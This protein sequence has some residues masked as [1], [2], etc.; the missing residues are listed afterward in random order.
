MKI[1][2]LNKKSSLEVEE[3][4][5][6][7][8]EDKEETKA[9]SVKD[10]QEYL[11]TKG[12][13]NEMK[14]LIN[15]TL[16]KIIESLKETKFPIKEER[17][18]IMAIW[19]GSISGNIQIALR[20]AKTGKWLTSQ[21]LYELLGLIKDEDDFVGV[22][23][24]YEIKVLIG[25]VYRPAAYYRI[26][27]FNEEHDEPETINPTLAVNNAG[28]IKATFSGLTQNEIA[29]ITYEDIKVTIPETLEYIYSFV[30]EEES[31]ANAVPYIDTV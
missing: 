16:D 29:G 10:F 28:F 31:F 27:D 17:N 21:D 25:D 5:L 4:D 23:T 24:G 11:A 26:L 30:G 15:C 3:E 22:E 12:M 14:L 18:Y 20:N 19:I 9:I 8:I 13:V 1:S 7:I 2:S 6:L